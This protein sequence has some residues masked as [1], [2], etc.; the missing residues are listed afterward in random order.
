M[1]PASAEAGTTHVTIARYESLTNQQNQV[2]SVVGETVVMV[3][4]IDSANPFLR[5]VTVNPSNGAIKGSALR[6]NL[7]S[8]PCYPSKPVESIYSRH[9]LPGYSVVVGSGLQ[10]A[11]LPIAVQSS[12]TPVAGSWGCLTLPPAAAISGKPTAVT[13]IAGIGFTDGRPRL[14]VGTDSGVVIEY[15]RSSGGSITLH[16]QYDLGGTSPIHDLGP[17]PQLSGI[18]LGVAAGSRLAGYRMGVATPIKLFELSHPTGSN[19]RAFRP[20]EPGDR[21]LTSSSTELHVAFCDGRSDHVFYTELPATLVGT[22]WLDYYVVPPAFPLPP[23]GGLLPFSGALA[24]LVGAQGDVYYRPGYLNGASAV[25]CVVQVSEAQ[26]QPCSPCPIVVAGDVDNTG[27]ITASD[28]IRMVSFVFK[29]GTTPQPCRA[30]G[31]V[32]CSGT[33]NASDVI[34]LVNYVFKGA[35]PPCNVCSLFGGTWSCP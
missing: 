26:W 31:D 19:V 6:V 3:G 20:F 15:S 33:I 7:P 35:A 10:V 2:T 30:S 28:L 22:A 5:A 8:G 29:G 14:F 17:I 11:T 32:N 23:S 12:G 4:M 18:M 25:G 1:L 9:F 16:G 13:E 24:L 27:N 21:L 34:A